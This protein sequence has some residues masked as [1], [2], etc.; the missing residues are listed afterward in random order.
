MFNLFHGS[1]GLDGPVDECLLK[2]IPHR[3]RAGAMNAG[4]SIH[5]NVPHTSFRWRCW[6]ASHWQGALPKPSHDNMHSHCLQDWNLERCNCH[7]AVF[8]EGSGAAGING[9]LQLETC[10]PGSSQHVTLDGL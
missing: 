9:T 5:C 8:Q 1:D 2:Q 6:K 3:D 10:P 7:W 4:F